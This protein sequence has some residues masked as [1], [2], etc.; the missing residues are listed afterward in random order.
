MTDISIAIVAYPNCLKST[1]SGLEEM[2]FLATKLSQKYDQQPTKFHCEIITWP[3]FFATETKH[4]SFNIV[5]LPPSLDH[6]FNTSSASSLSEWLKTQH[7]QGAILTSVCAGL[8][9]LADTG[10]LAHKKVTTHWAL[11]DTFHQQYPDIELQSDAILINEGDIISAGGMMSWVDLGLELIAQQASPK[12][13]RQL[14]KLLVVDTGQREQRYYQ[15]FV[16]NFAHGDSN[17][18]QIQHVIQNNSHK[19]IKV[20]DLANSA[21]ITVRTFQRRFTKAT[22]FSPQLYIQ[23]IRIQKS[24]DLLESTAYSFERI[25]REVGYEDVNACRKAFNKIIGLSPQA[26]RQRFGTK[27]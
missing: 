4:A 7:D 16:P 17:I 11:V 5:I 6:G 9:L 1:I 2:F 22:G 21:N 20:T 14:G 24:C 12:L 26:F 25:A 23:R 13:M 27:A 19:S 8:F 3:D 10:L 18:V 15:Q